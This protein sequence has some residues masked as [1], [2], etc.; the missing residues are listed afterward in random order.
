MFLSFIF[1]SELLH[2]RKKPDGKAPLFVLQYRCY[3]QIPCFVSLFFAWV[4]RSYF[5]DAREPMQNEGKIEQK[6][7]AMRP[8]FVL[9]FRTQGQS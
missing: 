2:H 1:L 9:P 4:P 5:E 6:R 7:G 3:W 8:L